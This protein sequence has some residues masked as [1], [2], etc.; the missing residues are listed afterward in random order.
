MSYTLKRPATADG[1]GKLTVYRAMAVGM[2]PQY[3]FPQGYVANLQSFRILWQADN[4]APTASSL[5]GQ[6]PLVELRK[7]FTELAY[8]RVRASARPNAVSRLTSLFCFA[9]PFE[10]FASTEGTGEAKSI[11]V[12]SV[13]PEVP[14]TV[15]DMSAFEVVHPAA[16]TEDGWAQAWQD[17]TSKAKDYWAPGRPPQQFRVA[18][19][20]LA[21]QIAVTRRPCNCYGS[22]NRKACYRT[23]S[24]RTDAAAS[25]LASAVLQE[26]RR[27]RFPRSG[28]EAQAGSSWRA[29]MCGFLNA[30]KPI[31]IQQAAPRPPG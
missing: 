20:L 25:S 2:V 6:V 18:E 14:W 26:G 28:G 1:R 19:V 15:V 8:E 21:G 22:W 29:A 27:L 12:I 7:V 13:P 4:L 30:K 31:H 24:R 3:L 5:V 11:L 16:P 10:A 23:E 9:D 17:A